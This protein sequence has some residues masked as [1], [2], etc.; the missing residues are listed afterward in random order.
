MSLTPE[1]LTIGAL[2]PYTIAA[3]LYGAMWL[4]SSRTLRLSASI[5][6][7]AGLSVNLLQLVMR[8]IEANQPPFKTLFESLVLL[9]ACI[10]IVYLFVE[11]VYRARI[12]GLPAAAGCALTMLYAL[13]RQDKEAVNLP[14]A[15][16]SG[17][18]IPH[19]VVYFFGYAALFVAFC[20]SFV[21]LLR[22]KPIHLRRPDLI[23]GEHINLESL[24]D[25]A[26][27]FGF[28]LLTTGLLMG[29][30]WAKSAWGDY[31]VWDPKETWSLVT[32]LLFAAYLHLYYLGGWRGRRLAVLVLVGFSAV[33][34]TYLGMH[35]LPTAEQSAH[36]Y[37]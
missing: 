3:L 6:L 9:A 16:Q 36:V 25:G 8:A 11:L 12:L 34:F 7:G 13:L 27:R 22:P 29:A 28:A 4:T 17:W 31:W 35:L 1:T 24:L 10:A 5:M 15:L 20:A 30:V 18:F 21:Y 23:A 37:Q 19:V 33:M 14:P 2:V 26:V 32:W